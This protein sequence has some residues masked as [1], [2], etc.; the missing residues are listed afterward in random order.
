M[1]VH[2]SARI[3]PSAVIS[4]EASIG[5]NVVIHPFVVIDGAVTIDA[6]TEVLPHVHMVGPMT[7]GQRNKIGASCVLGSEPQHLAYAGQPASVE[8]GDHNVFRE[9]VTVH[10]GSHV[11]GWGVTRIGSHCFFMAN[12]HCGH[13]A[14]VGNYVIMANGSLLGG[15][16][17]VQD[18]AFV[19]GNS[20]VHQNARIG[21]LA[22]TTGCIAIVQDLLPFMTLESRHEVAGVNVIGLRR[23]GYSASD[24]A[25]VRE[26][27]KIIYRSGNI[28]KV[29]FTQLAER[30]PDHPL[31]T[32]I[33]E[34]ARGSKRGVIRP[35]GTNHQDAE[36]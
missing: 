17:I 14:Q 15:H 19:S 27:Y 31:I 6:G 29:S 34:F 22:I 32:E 4:A 36:A 7:I 30:F 1:P 28:L 12:S 24:I 18:R 13:D 33:L 3:H 20:G 11:P 21:R 26:A 10:R 25:T 9:Y 5:P 2:S 23:A 35:I 16:A 8:I